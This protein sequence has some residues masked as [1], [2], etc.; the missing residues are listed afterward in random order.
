MGWAVLIIALMIISACM[1]S[2]TGKIILSAGMIALGC[3]VVD[4]ITGMG[5]FV[6]LAKLCAIVIVVVIVGVIVLAIIGGEK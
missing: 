2:K 5:L 3:L 1:E 4:L 6:T